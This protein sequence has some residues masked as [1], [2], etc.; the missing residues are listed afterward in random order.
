LFLKGFFVAHFFYTFI[1]NPHHQQGGD[2]DPTIII[3]QSC[4]LGLPPLLGL[5]ATN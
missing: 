3:V 2:G 5:L 4:P 1:M